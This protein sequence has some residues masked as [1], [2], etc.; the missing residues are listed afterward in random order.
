MEEIEG[1]EPAYLYAMGDADESPLLEGEK[2]GRLE[3]DRA[4]RAGK[5]TAKHK[6][7]GWLS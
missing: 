7:V 1:R 3:C 4:P 6:N 2:M 5:G